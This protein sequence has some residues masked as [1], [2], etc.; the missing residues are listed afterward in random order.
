L[1]RNLPPRAVDHR[2]CGAQL[3]LAIFHGPE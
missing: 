2:S 3:H 1:T